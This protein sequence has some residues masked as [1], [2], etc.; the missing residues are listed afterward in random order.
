[1]ASNTSWPPTM[2][3][4]IFTGGNI[5]FDKLLWTLEDSEATAITLKLISPDGD[6]NYP[7]QV[8]ARV[9][10]SLPSSSTLRIQYE[11]TTDAPTLVNLTNHSYWNLADGG[12]SSVLDH[13]ISLFADFYT[14]VD[15]TSIP[16]GEV[17]AVTGAMDLRQSVKI[18]KGIKEADNGLG[19]D[20]NYVLQGKFDPTSKLQAV[21][22][23]SHSGSG[24][25]MTVKTDQPG[26]QFYTGNYLNG[27]PGRTGQGYEKH[28]GFCLETQCFPNAV[29]VNGAHF[30]NV[31]RRPGEP[32]RNG[33]T[34]RLPRAARSCSQ[35]ARV[36]RCFHV[37]AP[38]D[39][40]RHFFGGFNLAEVELEP[41]VK[42]DV[43]IIR[44]RV[45][46]LPSGHAYVYFETWEVFVHFDL[47]RRRAAPGARSNAATWAVA[48]SRSMWTGRRIGTKSDCRSTG[49]RCTRQRTA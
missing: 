41:D 3:P 7:G 27:F 20:H 25:W 42:Q 30:S 49:S 47:R 21:A 11:A 16:T 5:G 48:S 18:G 1:M 23:V 24:R 37:A 19:Y 32:Q 35:L 13:E 22:H 44:R 4:T 28:H 26:V 45:D 38:R 34:R 10:Y 33:A 12:I 39:E 40:I 2:A 17:R 43:E 6:E 36:P 29:N 8:T 9:H 15:D 14:P 46:Q 31:V